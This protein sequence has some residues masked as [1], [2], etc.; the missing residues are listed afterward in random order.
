[1]LEMKVIVPLEKEGEVVSVIEDNNVRAVARLRGDEV[2]VVIVYAQQAGAAHLM[3]DL[4]RIGCGVAFGRIALNSVDV[5]KPLPRKIIKRGYTERGKEKEKETEKAMG[6]EEAIDSARMSIEEIYTTVSDGAGLSSTFIAYSI[7]AALIA[8]GGLATDNTVQI[9]ASMLLSPM[10]SPVVAFTFGVVVRDRSMWLPAIGTELVCILICLLVGVFTGL[11][12]APVNKSL[13]WPTNEMVVQIS[14]GDPVNL[15]PGLFFAIPSGVGV[16]V[17]VAMGGKGN[18]FVGVAIA[19][20]L[21][22]PVVNAG[23]CLAFGCLLLAF[24]FPDAQGNVP[25]WAQRG[26]TETTGPG[27]EGEEEAHR[28]LQ[29]GAVS[30]A[31]FWMNVVCIFATAVV[32]FKIKRIEPVRKQLSYYRELPPLRPVPGLPRRE[33]SMLSAEGGAGAG[34]GAGAGGEGSPHPSGQRGK[35]GQET[36]KRH[37]LFGDEDEEKDPQ[38]KPEASSSSPRQKWK[39]VRDYVT[40][41]RDRA[42]EILKNQQESRG[43]RDIARVLRQVM[44]EEGADREW[45]AENIRELFEQVQAEWGDGESSEGSLF[46]QGAVRNVVRELHAMF[47]RGAQRRGSEAGTEGESS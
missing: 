47:E 43:E 39:Q 17:S 32:V 7:V 1:M 27:W 35:E 8:G 30:F 41:S 31:L 10:M 21:L 33:S 16:G 15:L 18:S 28:L 19:A 2:V 23:L 40:A 3:K 46:S 34:A 42:R 29:L 13:G 24:H 37:E 11:T 9:V 5:V 45:Q 25:E 14:R 26:E 12:L 36:G 38:E 20:S 44:L 6:L 22:P 4:D